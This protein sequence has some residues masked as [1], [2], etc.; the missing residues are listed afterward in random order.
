M[1]T[2]QLTSNGT[3]YVLDTAGNVTQ[4]STVIGTWNTDSSN[5][6]V[7]TSNSISTNNNPP[8]PVFSGLTWQFV[9]NQLCLSAGGAQVIN[10]DTLTDGTLVDYSVDNNARLRV[11]LSGAGEQS[12]VLSGSWDFD[13]SNVLSITINDTTSQFASGGLISRVTNG[14]AYSFSDNVDGNLPYVLSFKGQWGQDAGDQSKLTFT[15]QTPNG[16]A[17]FTLPASLTFNRSTNQLQY[18][19]T[20]NG[21]VSWG[22]SFTGALVINDNWTI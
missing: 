17:T 1:S 9:N 13:A 10:F 4:N 11:M 8:L 3:T 12:F 6:I 16:P 5:N 15:Y 22:V 14:F 7:L 19:Y 20:D 2:F 21:G 18:S